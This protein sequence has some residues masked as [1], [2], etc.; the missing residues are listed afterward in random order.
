[1]RSCKWKVTS[2]NP[3]WSLTKKNVIDPTNYEYMITKYTPMF[4]AVREVPPIQEEVEHKFIKKN[5]SRLLI[6]Y[7]IVY[8]PKP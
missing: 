8:L 3:L 2:S 6:L 5:H 4:E 7:P 1:M